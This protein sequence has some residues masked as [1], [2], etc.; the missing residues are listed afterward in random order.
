MIHAIPKPNNHHRLKEYF[1]AQEIKEITPED[2]QS[3]LLNSC[4]DHYGMMRLLSDLG[5]MV[6]HEKFRKG[7]SVV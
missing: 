2:L 1:D 6:R 5:R 3:K 7:V 4:R